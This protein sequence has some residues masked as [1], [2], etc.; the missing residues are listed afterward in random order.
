[1]DGDGL[2]LLDGLRVR[3]AGVADVVVPGILHQDVGEVQVS[4]QTLRHSP[5][6]RQTLEICTDT[7]RSY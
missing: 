4:V 2:L 3:E 5:A 7:H 1:M 6:L